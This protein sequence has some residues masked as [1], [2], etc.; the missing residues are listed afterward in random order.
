[1]NALWVLAVK[2]HSTM[3]CTSATTRKKLRAKVLGLRTFYLQEVRICV[4]IS[5]TVHFFSLNHLSCLD[6]FEEN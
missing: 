4:I 6:M 5:F 2:D 3:F 1:M